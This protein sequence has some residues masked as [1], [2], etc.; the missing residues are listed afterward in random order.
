M[1]GEDAKMKALAALALAVALM[2]GTATAFA[3][4]SNQEDLY[5][6]GPRDATTPDYSSYTG[7]PE[8]LN[9]VDM[10]TQANAQSVLR[11]DPND[12]LQLDSDRNG[13]ACEIN[14]EPRDLN[15]VRR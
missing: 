15:P 2:A 7:R 13:I 5:P 12:P 3:Q 14:P 6:S 4:P 11:A 9:C 1:F 8:A 10:G